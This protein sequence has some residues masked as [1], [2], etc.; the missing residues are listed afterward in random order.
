MGTESSA[1]GRGTRERLL[2]AKIAKNRRGKKASE[3]R[4]YQV[5]I[6]ESRIRNVEALAKSDVYAED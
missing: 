6:C 1:P 2:S 4:E 3:G 5:P